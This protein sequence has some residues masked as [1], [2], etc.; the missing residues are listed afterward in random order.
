MAMPAS[1][2]GL[3]A[4]RRYHILKVARPFVDLAGAERVLDTRLAEVILYRRFDRPRH[5]EKCLP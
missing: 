1:A 5:Q 4:P 3:D 2:L